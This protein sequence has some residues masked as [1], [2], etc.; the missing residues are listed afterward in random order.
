MFSHVFYICKCM[1]VHVCVFMGQNVSGYLKYIF[2]LT[3]KPLRMKV[4][5]KIVVI[6]I[7]FIYHFFLNAFGNLS[8][9]PQVLLFFEAFCAQRD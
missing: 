3:K 2:L 5:Y 4:L 1:C 7:L 8:F 6:H 9:G